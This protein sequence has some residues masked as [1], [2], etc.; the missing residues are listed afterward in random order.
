[1]KKLIL[2]TSL[3]LFS[4]QINA[5]EIIFEELPEPFQEDLIAEESEADNIP[6]E[7]E[8]AENYEKSYYH[9]ATRTMVTDTIYYYRWHHGDSIWVMMS[10]N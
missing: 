8:P 6:D 2:L 3:A 7:A 4:W 10:G 1:M 9:G 5:Q